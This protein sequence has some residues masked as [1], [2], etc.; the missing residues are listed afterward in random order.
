MSALITSVVSVYVLGA[1]DPKFRNAPVLAL[2]LELLGAVLFAVVG[3][4]VF[5]AALT[6]GFAADV[7]AVSTRLLGVLFAAGV[8]YFALLNAMTR[9]AANWLDEES[10]VL[11]ILGRGIAVGYPI[12]VV[13]AIR[14]FALSVPA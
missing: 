10:M 8:P 4:G 13:L 2:Q 12:L 5:V 7:P 6:L 11:P 1:F 3:V 9:L 14:R